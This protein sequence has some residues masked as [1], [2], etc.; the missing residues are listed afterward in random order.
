[1]IGTSVSIKS[2]ASKTPSAA[3]VRPSCCAGCGVASAPVGALIRVHGNGLVRRQVRGV[4]EPDGIPGV[5]EIEARKYECQR[6]GAV[7][8]VVPAGLLATR[9]YSAPSI[10]LALYLWLVAGLS[11][12]A[13]RERIG[14]WRVRGR[15]GG[16]GWAQLYRWVRAAPR[17]FALPRPVRLAGTARA[18]A[19]RVIAMLGGLGP[20]SRSSMPSRLFAGAALAC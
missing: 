16:R 13:V 7:M 19:S 14:A 17:L 3:E 1:M 6:C 18:I 8:T 2:W 9:Q 15:S 10:A 12:V 5:I 11:D 20:P 4:L